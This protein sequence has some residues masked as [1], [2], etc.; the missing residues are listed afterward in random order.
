MCD[1]DEILG[2][3]T[4]R[5]PADDPSERRIGFVIVDDSMRGRG[6]VKALVSM[7]ADY[8]FTELDATKVFFGIFENSISAIHCYEAV[9]FRCVS[10]PEI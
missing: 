10:R 9:V 2:Y 4:L 3:I 7:T 5:S 1:G 8:A 6:L